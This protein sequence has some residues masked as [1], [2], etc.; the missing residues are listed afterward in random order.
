MND[1]LNQ[2][3]SALAQQRERLAT[4]QNVATNG[5]LF[6]LAMAAIAYLESTPRLAIIF[7]AILGA[8]V[9]AEQLPPNARKLSAIGLYALAAGAA[10]GLFITL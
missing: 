1:N 10:I 5:R 7:A 3:T 2:A 9:I 4:M 8:S 6:I